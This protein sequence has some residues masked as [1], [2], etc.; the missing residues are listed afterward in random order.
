M[1][2]TK[3]QFE[4]VP[5]VAGRE[6]FSYAELLAQLTADIPSGGGN[7]GLGALL[8]LVNQTV[9][10]NSLH[11]VTW[12][13]FNERYDD[14]GFFDSVVAPT[15]L[16]I[17]A[18]PPISRV[19]VYGLAEFAVNTTGF[20]FVTMAQNTGQSPPG[21]FKISFLPVTGSSSTASGKSSPIKVTNGF[22]FF[23]LQVFQDSGANL[24]MLRAD[25]AVIIARDTG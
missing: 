23:E 9:P 19:R 3:A 2:I 1:D 20:R 6:T 18:T 10:N 24:T 17:P 22:S 8:S 16:S 13:S 7:V 14:F 15:R 25:F 5:N 4:N 11:T 12:A 21:T